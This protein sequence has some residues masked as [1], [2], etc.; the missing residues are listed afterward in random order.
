MKNLLKI[1]AFVASCF[2]SLSI[3]A[4]EISAADLAKGVTEVIEVTEVQP[5]YP[6][7]ALFRKREGSVMLKYTIDE[8]GAPSD[9]ELVSVNGSE[10]FVHSS[11]RALK[12]SRFQPVLLNGEPV[13]VSG[14]YRK[15]SYV[16]S[17]NYGKRTH[18]QN[19]LMASL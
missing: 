1:S 16:L 9:V 2:A 3:S 12:A 6:S 4:A 13:R 10:L 8:S 19:D 18:Q 11:I 5:E 7:I 14:L 15:Y 17:N